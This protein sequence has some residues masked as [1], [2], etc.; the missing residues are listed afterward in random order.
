MSE[1][2]ERQEWVL[3]Y[4]IRYDGWIV[5]GRGGMAVARGLEGRG[6]GT[7]NFRYA[8]TARGAVS[9]VFDPNENGHEFAK[10]HKLSVIEGGKDA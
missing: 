2:T 5:T 8:P 3:A 6:L 9:H 10:L 4:A 1:L 7:V